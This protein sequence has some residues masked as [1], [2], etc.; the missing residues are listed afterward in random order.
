MTQQE[1]DAIRSRHEAANSEINILYH[2]AKV[3]NKTF[4][5][6]DKAYA[7]TPALLD[8]V[9]EKDKRIAEAEKER[10]DVLKEYRRYRSEAEKTLDAYLRMLKPEQYLKEAQHDD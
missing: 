4:D 6:L 1:L 2:N 5:I 8:L 7:D 10:D 3:G 9:A